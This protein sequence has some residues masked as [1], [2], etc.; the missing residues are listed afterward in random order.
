MSDNKS[1]GN[2]YSIKRKLSIAIFLILLTI[3]VLLIPKVTREFF[4]GVFGYSL[5]L[6]LIVAFIC[7]FLLFTGKKINLRI[8]TIVLFFS[9]L[10]FAVLTIH[11][12][13]IRPIIDSGNNIILETY[14][15]SSL[16]GVIISIFSYLLYLVWPNYGFMVALPFVVCGLILLVA[17]M[18]II[19]KIDKRFPNLNKKKPANKDN[20]KEKLKNDIRSGSTTN[21]NALNNKKVVP[22]EINAEEFND[23]SSDASTLLF[24]DSNTNSYKKERNLFSGLTDQTTGRNNNSASLLFSDNI[25]QSNNSEPE[26]NVQYKLI[27]KN[28]DNTILDKLYTN[29][30][31]K[32]LL[33]DGIRKNKTDNQGIG[34]YSNDG[35][36]P[37]EKK[38]NILNEGIESGDSLE[39]YNKDKKLPSSVSDF[40]NSSDFLSTMPPIKKPFDE[41]KA[42]DDFNTP[43]PFEQTQIFQSINDIRE[44]RE[45]KESKD[46]VTEITE[47]VKKIIPTPIPKKTEEPYSSQI[48]MDSQIFSPPK[49][50]LTEKVDPIKLADGVQT[51]L[52]TS[53]KDNNNGINFLPAKPYKAP[54]TDKLVKTEGYDVTFPE[55]YNEFKQKIETTMA[56]FDVPAEVIGAR[57]GP[58]FTMY[59]LKLGPG[60]QISRIKSLKE[61]LKM[62]LEVNQIRILAPIEGRDAFGLEVPNKVR[63]V[64]GLRSLIESEEFKKSNSGIKI[65]FGKTLYG[66]NFVE[67]LAQMPHLLVA[68]ATGTGKSVFLNSLIVS[69]LYKYSPEEVRLILIDPK[70]VEL[71]VYKGLPNLLIAETIK[72]STQAVNVLKW[73]TDEMDRRYQFFEGVGCAN[74]DQYN[75]VIRDPKKDPKMFRI[76]LIIDEM[77]DLMLKGKGQVESYVVRI[78][79]LARACGIHMIIATQRPTVQVITGLIKSNILCRV[80][81]AVKSNVDSR[82]VLDDM[83]AED[84]LGKGDMIFSS[85]SGTTRM[86]GA[87]VELPEIKSICE[88]IRT[89]NEGVFDNQ[90]LDA[91]TVK[92]EVEESLE[93]T[94]SGQKEAKAEEFEVL[95]RQVMSLFIRKE[96]ASISSAQSAFNIGYMRAKKIVDALEARGY[97]GP[98]TAGTQGRE[99]LVTEADL[100]HDFED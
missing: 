49:K 68:G 56:E 29:Q 23:N 75:N 62:R 82:V 85:T 72:E 83:G 98:E 76:V 13:L 4:M 32:E 1:N 95:L 31:R 86:Q 90:L 42:L 22:G 80:A 78:A 26:K 10:F 2:I 99:I 58:T 6:Y 5:Y 52:F 59:E 77:A 12:V 9:I 3:L 50:D 94:E 84:L 37:F 87:L 46:I 11:N 41:K 18:P 43:L 27:D 34:P 71:A 70:R 38:Y 89:N 14:K 15:I 57:R 74:I 93:N 21:A 65:C 96:K 92:P 8:K 53:D 24:G 63:D 17:L 51:S 45:L 30:G 54:P 19:K 28:W 66:K 36:Y 40:S 16:G 33:E 44:K 81:F 97:L 55:D 48:S 7:D 67:D 79:Q 64:V 69:I 61:N 20:N 35:N 100:A 91:I 88:Y 47:P 39:N 25:T 73:L 60:Y